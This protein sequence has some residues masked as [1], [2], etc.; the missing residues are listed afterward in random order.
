MNRFLQASQV[1]SPALVDKGCTMS[2]QT[3]NWG[4]LGTSF[5]SDVMANAVKAEGRSTVRAV[6]GR[7][8]ERLNE[9]AD[10]HSIVS[11]YTSYQQ[12]IN[13]PQVDIIYIALPN[14]LHHEYVVMAAEAGKAVLCEKSLS[15]DLEK[16]DLIVDAVN[17]HQ[18]F[19]AEGLMYLNHPLIESLVGLLRSNDIGELKQIQTGYCAAISEFVNPDSKGAIFNLGCYP[20]SL[21]YRVISVLAPEQDLMS[22]KCQALGRRGQDGNICDTSAQMKVVDGIQV[23]LHCA[24]DYG[25]KHYFRILGS[26]GFVEMDSNPWLPEQTNSIRYG[27]Y[28]QQ[29]QSLTVEAK[30]DAFL[31]QVANIID[32]IQVGNKE[33]PFPAASLQDSKAIMSWL[34]EWHDVA[35]SSVE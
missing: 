33:L 31:Y 26:K 14:H 7:N 20:A 18:I 2:E 17:K 24:E 3:L 27:I 32:A 25:L 15:T 13:D 5:I 28:E 22:V 1:N 34:S 8:E 23:Q 10:K 16:T 9:F 29:E 35:A 30:G 6:A 12:L 21:V 19:F 4:F 11:R